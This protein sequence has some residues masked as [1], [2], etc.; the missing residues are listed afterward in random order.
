MH[1]KRKYGTQSF[2]YHSG[3]SGPIDSTSATPGHSQ[4]FKLALDEDKQA[5]DEALRISYFL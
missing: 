5:N 4:S 3:C 1:L 2:K